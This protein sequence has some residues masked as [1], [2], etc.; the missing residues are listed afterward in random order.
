V[1]LLHLGVVLFENPASELERL[2]R[3]FRA[4]ERD[5]AVELR[6]RFLDNSAAPLLQAVVETAFGQGAYRWTGENRGFGT[7]HNRGLQEAMAAGADGYLCVNP[8]AV[9][10]PRCVQELLAVGSTPGT[11]L[12]DAR[13]FPEEH[14]KPYDQR[15]GETPW[16]AGTVLLV[17][18]EAFL[19]T[20]GFDERIFL[21]G[22]DVDLSWRARAAGLV[23]RTAA[24][25]LVLHWVEQ[26]PLAAS[27]EEAVIRSAAYLG[28]KWGA[29]GFARRYERLYRRLT[30]RPLELGEVAPVPAADR[31]HA[32]FAHGVRFA[33]SRW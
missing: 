28:R 14:P 19:A 29:P 13:T 15:T 12:V 11:G 7:A 2:V 20:G 26:R 16:C 22:E 25:A 31:R 8:D 21:Y 4:L 18:R 10:H 6:F 24:R 30:G 17:R 23:T 33:R 27:R 32:D 3:S 9:L 5:S 1:T